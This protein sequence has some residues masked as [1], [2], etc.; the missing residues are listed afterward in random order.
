LL[1]PPFLPSSNFSVA[2]VYSLQVQKLTAILRRKMSACPAASEPTPRRRISIVERSRN[3]R[4]G[5][6]SRGAWHTGSARKGD[7]I[8]RGTRHAD[9][10][11]CPGAILFDARPPHLSWRP[12]TQRSP[13]PRAVRRCR[14]ARAHHPDRGLRIHCRGRA[15]LEH[16]GDS[17]RLAGYD[18]KR[19]HAGARN[20]PS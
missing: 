14:A 7:R 8:S 4:L 10:R 9:R 15:G 20:R 17:A 6:L 1:A 13:I 5:C 18:F 19:H 11:E 3:R 16:A 12:R 2:S